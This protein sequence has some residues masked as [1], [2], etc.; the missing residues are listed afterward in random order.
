[1]KRSVFLYHVVPLSLYACLMLLFL[2]SL[3]VSK[4][5]PEIS[6]ISPEQ[7]RSGDLMVISGR[8]FGLTRNKSKVWLDQSPMPASA[9]EF[10][11]DTSVKVRI[12]SL[13]GSG[14][15][16]LETTGGRSNGAL[17]ILSER[18]PDRS[19][20]AFLPG[21]PYLSRIN[22]SLFKP[23][24]LVV[25][26][27]DKLGTR[28]KNSEIL[29]NLTGKA[30]ESMLDE[31]DTGDYVVVPPENIAGW[32][33]NRISFYLPEEANCGPVYIK[34]TAGYSNP[35]SIEVERSGRVVLSEPRSLKI[36]QEILVTRVGALPG[37]NLVLWVPQPSDGPGQKTVNYQSNREAVREDGLLKVYKL[38]ELASGFEYDVRSE[39][40]L[41]LNSV[42][43]QPVLSEIPDYYE[44]GEMLE[45][46]L[47]DE[48]DIPASYFT[49]T[50][51]AVIKRE[52]NPYQKAL[53]LFDYI[54]WK[55]DPV[56]GYPDQDYTK[57]LTD[58][59][60]DSFGYA[61]L[62]VSLCR[63]AGVPSRIISGLWFP[64]RGEKGII[65]YWS[66][67]YLPGFGWFAADPGAADGI[68]ESVLPEGAESPGGWGRLNNGYV[69]FSRGSL[70]GTPYS[71]R[72]IRIDFR[73]YS[74][75]NIFEE[76]IGNLESCSIF[77]ENIAIIAE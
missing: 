12:P 24:E 4:R 55:M 17:Y 54:Q 64:D 53:L 34:T 19:S 16:F 35:V 59:K 13:S 56:P 3:S 58:R 28:K 76:W 44:N 62:F 21:K 51:S 50:A 52:K 75:Q 70:Q 32:T 7:V 31:P 23:G 20:G 30:P 68:L 38:D 6:S 10:W 67:I 45:S 69:A 60:A 66:E 61:S 49:R 77:W 36:L 57:W 8:N 43:Y 27:G 73:S 18:L 41:S 39:Y 15:V 11:S 42:E 5:Q 33:D 65:H 26:D 72:S 40:E 48:E 9:I 46:F 37:N 47:K 74:Q 25:L 2:L 29:V 71:D 63:S 22:S 14:L 1:M